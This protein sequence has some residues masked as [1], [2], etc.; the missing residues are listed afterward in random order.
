MTM[1]R[2]M[3]LGGTP[4]LI[5]PSRN[6]KGRQSHRP[7]RFLTSHLHILNPLLFSPAAALA[8]LCPQFLSLNFWPKHSLTPS[9]QALRFFSP[10]FLLSTSTVSLY[11]TS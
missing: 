7:E 1:T 6:V 10:S 9:T 5:D 4:G 8:P 2:M 11:R 3:T